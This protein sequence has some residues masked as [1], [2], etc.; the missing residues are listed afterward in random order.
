MACHELMQA[1]D[2]PRLARGL[3]PS[4][5]RLCCRLWAALGGVP[6]RRSRQCPQRTSAIASEIPQPRICNRPPTSCIA[7]ASGAVSFTSFSAPVVTV[8]SSSSSPRPGPG[9]G[10]GAVRLKCACLGA[11]GG[12][13]GTGSRSLHAC[14]A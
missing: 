4:P 13:G 2:E 9:G 6:Q 11:G 10:D 3:P 14:A 5:S 12:G 8:G 1:G 7:M